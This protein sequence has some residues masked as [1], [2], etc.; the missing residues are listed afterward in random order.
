MGWSI[1]APP[2]SL[3]WAQSLLSG[4]NLTG[5]ADTSPNSFLEQLVTSMGGTGGE[6]A[7]IEAIFSNVPQLDTIVGAIT[8]DAG[9][10]TL[11]QNYFAGLNA[12]TNS[13]LEQLIAGAAVVDHRWMIGMRVAEH[14]CHRHRDHQRSDR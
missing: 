6:L 5:T 13:L 2:T 4:F 10:I 8:G 3:N 12:S 7:D 9:D 11:L 1:P 14:R